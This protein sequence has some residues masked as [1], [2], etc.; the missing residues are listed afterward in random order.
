MR[1]RHGGLEVGVEEV[2]ADVGGLGRQ[3]TRCILND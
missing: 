3:R 1:L 2:W